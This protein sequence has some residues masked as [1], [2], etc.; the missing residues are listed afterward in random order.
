MN[1][2]MKSRSQSFSS[3]Q[4]IETSSNNNVLRSCHTEYSSGCK[5]RFHSSHLGRPPGNDSSSNIKLKKPTQVAMKSPRIAPMKQIEKVRHY[6]VYY[7]Y[8]SKLLLDDYRS[9]KGKF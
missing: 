9:Q 3:F 1:D 7:Y 6:L 5:K 4:L 8:D 2:A